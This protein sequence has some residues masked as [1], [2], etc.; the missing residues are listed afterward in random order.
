ML[1][2]RY[3]SWNGCVRCTFKTHGQSPH[4]RRLHIAIIGKWLACC[5]G[6]FCSVSINGRTS[7]IDFCTRLANWHFLGYVVPKPFAVQANKSLQIVSL[8]Q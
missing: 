6:A 8:V 5:L 1:V 7:N 3:F 2:G 4:H